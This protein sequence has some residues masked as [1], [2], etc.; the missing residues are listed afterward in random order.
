[1]ADLAELVKRLRDGEYSFNEIRREAALALERLSAENVELRDQRDRVLKNCI[2]AENGWKD[3]KE[4]L[5]ALER[6]IAEAP[7]Y[8]EDEGLFMPKKFLGKRV[9]LLLEDSDG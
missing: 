9:R 7:I 2:E 5:I 3:A 1:M 4:C 8:N 6:R